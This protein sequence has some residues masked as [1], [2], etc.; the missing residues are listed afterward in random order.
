MT[1]CTLLAEKLAETVANNLG[2]STFLYGYSAKHADRK[3]LSTLRK[4]EYE[5]LQNR[6]SN[7]ETNHNEFTRYP[8][9]GPKQWCDATKKSG[10]ITIG[11]RDILLHTMPILT[12]LMQLLQR[13]LVLSFVAVVD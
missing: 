3:L 5:G 12:K 4:G 9:F 7:G 13:K 1:Q 11:S 10:G 8:D 2:V 6:L